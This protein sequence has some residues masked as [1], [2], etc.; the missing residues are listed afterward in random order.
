MSTIRLALLADC[1][2][3]VDGSTVTPSAAHLF[4]LLLLFTLETERRLSRQELQRYLF[5]PDAD[6]KL[7]AH[8]LRQL[9]YRLRQFGLEFDERPAGV[10]LANTTLIDYL[11]PLRLAGS[12]GGN[13]L[14]RE[15]VAF[16]P[17]YA[18]RLPEPFL[19]WLDRMRDAADGR[20]RALLLVMLEGLRR[21]HTWT[22]ALCVADVL[23]EFDPL[24]E[25]VVTARAEALAMLHR[26][27]EALVLLTDFEREEGGA[28]SATMVRQLRARIGKMP[29]PKRESSLKGRESTLSLLHAEWTSLDI[30]GARQSALIGHSGVGKTRLAEAFSSR[31]ALLGGH[32]LRYVCDA[33]S[34]SQPLSLFSQLLPELR[35]MRGSL[36]A[37]PRY[38][39][40]LDRIRPT[41]G[42]KEVS[43]R[44]DISL[45]ALRTEVQ[46]AVIDLLEAVSAERRILLVVDDAHF[47]DAASSSILRALVNSPNSA[48]IH[49][50]VCIRPSHDKSPLLTPSQRGV[51]H[52]LEPLP[53][54]ESR[55]LLSE[56][57]EGTNSPESHVEWCL[58]H[59]AGNP[60]YLHA[61][62]LHTSPSATAVPFDILSLASSSYSSLSPKSR[63]V[64]ESC[65]LLGRFATIDR[66]LRV[67]AVDEACMLSALRELEE[68]DLVQFAG[69]SLSGPHALLNDAL[70]TLIPSSVAALLHKRVATMLEE[71]CVSEQYASSLAWASA[72]SWLAVGNPHAATRLMRRCASHAV[73]VGE[74]KAASDL[75]CQVVDAPLPPALRAELLDDLIRYAQAAGYQSLAATSLRNR[76]RV[77]QDLAE[78]GNALKAIELRIIEAD[79][80]NGGQL[81]LAI[82][83]LSA[84]LEDDSTDTSLRVQAAVR[85]MVVADQE[86]DV[87]L[88][89]GVNAWLLQLRDERGQPDS[90]FL[91][92][93]LVF[94]TAFGDIVRARRLADQ[95]L[96]AYPQPTVAE[97]SIR[98]RN[99][100]TYALYRLRA[101]DEAIAL[102]ETS[103]G[104]MRAHGVLNQALYSASL[105]TEIALI[106]GDFAIA[107]AWLALGEDVARGSAAHELSP[108]SGLYSNA[109][110]LAMR[111]GRYEEA[112]KLIF[113]PRRD[114][115][116]LSA[117]RYRAISCA[118]SIR[119]RQL[120]DTNDIAPQEI[121]SLESL[122]RKGCKLGGQDPIVEALWCSR[123]LEGDVEGASDLLF[124]YL[125]EHRR[126]QSKAD[127][128]LRHTTAADD[129]WRTF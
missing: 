102:C 51:I 71:E 28:A 15:S 97:D 112:E 120:R 32:T 91:R 84:L 8:N 68:H 107:A 10:K 119:L 77:A 125:T 26:R 18:P 48:A 33:H 41:G 58:K 35:A 79:L 62:A 25:E 36:G 46:S 17:S 83:P 96:N 1:V 92:A 116:I 43:H 115:S 3:E 4:A 128:S 45:E 54:E 52:H 114:F 109:G 13:R 129:A 55:S 89:H 7:A 90:H 31:V 80:L 104:F 76:Y 108:N 78:D 37:A 24:N 29:V 12:P 82:A 16:L 75:L 19:E 93:E 39:G 59:A 11:E 124:E 69:G 74:P 100:A 9:L 85:L 121:A 44:E 57:L 95:L 61:L 99:F 42:T 14:S 2:I 47:L 49:L 23:H 103:Y 111:E 70:L 66:V 118:Q 50:L 86:L 34:R 123:V 64:L 94:H 126:E 105:R 98:A 88:A 101:F 22:A 106:D 113:A 122:Y 40:A 53:A 87:A 72:R 6:P 20:V 21:S 56:L 73:A 60:F 67:A 63:T 81:A 30:T 27:N 5:A 38:N 127:W 65:L 117:A 110:I